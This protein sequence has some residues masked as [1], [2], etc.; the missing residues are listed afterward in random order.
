MKRTSPGLT[1]PAVVCERRVDYEPVAD[2]VLVALTT[3]YGRV[4]RVLVR[5]GERP[6]VAAA[7]VA[8]GLHV[9]QAEA[10]EF[11]AEAL[12]RA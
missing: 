4:W 2:G 3:P 11:A 8:M 6:E 9:G 1:R 10:V 7:G 12:R 5:R